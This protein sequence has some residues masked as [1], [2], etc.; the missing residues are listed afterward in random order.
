MK[1]A[2]PVKYALKRIMTEKTPYH[3]VLRFFQERY[4]IRNTLVFLAVSAI[5]FWYV[6]SLLF[7][8]PSTLPG[9]DPAQHVAI[10]RWMINSKSVLVPYSQF[11]LTDASVGYY[12]AFW[13][14]F[15]ALVHVLTGVNEVDLMR[16]FILVVFFLG[17]YAY[18]LLSKELSE[19]DSLKGVF[20]YFV[21]S[22]SI[23]LIVKSLR[24]GIYGEIIA[25]WLLFPLF[26]LSFLRGKTL[27]SVLALIVI[28]AIHN[29]SAMMTG[30]LV[31]S[32]LI[33][34]CLHKDWQKAKFTL[35]I[36]ALAL[37]LSSPL[38][39]Y[40]YFLTFLGVITDSARSYSSGLYAFNFFIMPS[41]LSDL[42]FYVG[43]T[44]L[45]LISIFYRHYRWLPLWF[46]TY[47][48]AQ[49]FFVQERFVREMCIP[50][51]LSMGIVLYDIAKKASQHT[52]IKLAYKGRVKEYS[53]PKNVKVESLILIL[54]SFTVAYNGVIHIALES[55]PEVTNYF[56]Q[57][58]ADAYNW[59]N[60]HTT[61]ADATL[62]LRDL[63]SWAR[64]YLRDTV[65]EVW[66]P[67]EQKYLSIPDRKVN[68]E[69]TGALLN[70]FSPEANSTFRKYNISYFIL[71]S[72]LT[73]RWY[74]IETKTFAEALLKTD[75]ENSSF[76]E[77]IYN[78]TKGD[79]TIEIY[80]IHI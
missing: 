49:F 26:L 19:G 46:S 70:P 4:V 37:A 68:D 48:I 17:V 77:C 63:D 41:F 73:G 80:E 32:F 74:T 38:L 53:L 62:I 52:K 40:N 14:G 72:P 55:T 78:V 58:K 23:A 20:I 43:I 42:T 2:N 10:M 51:A 47:M 30:L 76:Y 36:L 61:S 3:Q 1:G 18:W 9:V 25:M 69:L 35:K 67:A 71:S 75:Y 24:D 15:I 64:V 33:M 29:L 21:L 39:Y 34:Y 66:S 8:S 50:L 57:N 7:S 44:C 65:Y 56:T 79:E 60:N 31:L 27:Y 28:I 59:L 13:Q 45:V 11:F 54:L 6:F 22:F 12:P 5:P 16:Y